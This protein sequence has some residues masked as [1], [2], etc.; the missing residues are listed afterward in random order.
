[1]L[2]KLRFDR[3]VRSRKVKYSSLAFVLIANTTITLA[4]AT[5]STTWR[6]RNL[7]K[8]NKLFFFWKKVVDK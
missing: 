2:K 6:I 4:Y 8:Q 5:S 7:I 1:M 3:T